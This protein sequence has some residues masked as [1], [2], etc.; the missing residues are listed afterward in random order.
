MNDRNEWMQERRTGI[1]GS[2]APAVLGISPW[3]TALDVYFA[4]VCGIDSSSSPAAEWGH[5]LQG[6]I[7]QAYADYAERE[8]ICR[9]AQIQRSSDHPWMIATLDYVAADRIVEVKRVG[10]RMA[11]HWADGV[12]PYVYA[13]VQHQMAVAGYDRGDVA[14]LIG[15][16]D[17]RIIEVPRDQ[18]YIDAMIEREQE[19]WACVERREPPMPD[20]AHPATHA[21]MRAVEPMAGAADVMLGEDTARLAYMHQEIGA[22]IRWWQSQRDEIEARLVHA[23]GFASRAVLPDGRELRRTT[24]RRKEYVV[25]ASESVRFSIKGKVNGE[26]ARQYIDHAAQ[27]IAEQ[28]AD[29]H[30][31]EA[32]TAAGEA[33]ERA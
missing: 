11:E 20:F 2:D 10:A 4:K 7:A 12:P 27:R 3:A 19:F 22:V 32:A 21:L 15:D 31:G 25:P 23:M 16:S 24:V 6:A 18:P 26:A 14:A 13:Q 33:A 30:A 5:R 1:G 28:R 29:A 17:F 8:L 9:D